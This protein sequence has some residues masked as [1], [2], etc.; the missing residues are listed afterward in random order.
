M[1]GGEEEIFGGSEGEM[2]GLNDTIG[3]EEINSDGHGERKAFAELSKTIKSLQKEVQSYKE[4]NEKLLQQLNDR[5][6]H[7]LN[8]I[9]RQMSSDPRKGKDSHKEKKHS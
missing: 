7:S 5:L 4:E 2:R 9:Q 8:E 6:V 1:E 3:N